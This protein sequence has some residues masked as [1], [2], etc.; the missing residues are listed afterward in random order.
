MSLGDCGAAYSLTV[1]LVSETGSVVIPTATGPATAP[2]T[3][4]APTTTSSL[5]YVSV[6][7]STVPTGTGGPGPVNNAT[8]ST[9]SLPA[10]V[11]SNEGGKKGIQGAAELF[12]VGLAGLAAAL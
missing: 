6:P 3:F 2:S 12:A 10:Q 1:S 9:A 7:P 11:T 8:V 5:I 4:A